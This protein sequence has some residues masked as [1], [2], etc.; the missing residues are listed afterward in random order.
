MF[1]MLPRVS[2]RMCVCMCSQDDDGR[3]AEQYG[4]ACRRAEGH[5][6]DWTFSEDCSFSGDVEVVRFL[7]LGESRGVP[8]KEDCGIFYWSWLTGFRGDWIWGSGLRK[9]LEIQNYHHRF[10]FILYKFYSV[11]GWKILILQS[12][13][14]IYRSYITIS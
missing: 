9:M 14:I 10:C 12:V 5:K 1:I 7:F 3:A 4:V 6:E 13:S 2:V 8:E 11:S